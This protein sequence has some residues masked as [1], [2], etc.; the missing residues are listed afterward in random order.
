MTA[1]SSVLFPAAGCARTRTSLRMQLLHGPLG[2]STHEQGNHLQRRL[3]RGI[4]GLPFGRARRIQYVVHHFARA[5]RR[6]ADTDAQT[7]EIP[8]TTEIGNDVAQAIVPA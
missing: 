7:V 5:R 3:D 4:D 8:V 1:I 6:A 2:L